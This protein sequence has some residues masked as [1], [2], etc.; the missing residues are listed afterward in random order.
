M[1]DLRE[2]FKALDALEAPDLQQEI[3]T[4]PLRPAP[5]P[6]RR[7]RL[8]AGTL[9]GL[10]AVLGIAVGGWA[11]LRPREAPRPVTEPTPGVTAPP[12][13]QE[14]FDIERFPGGSKAVGVRGRLIARAVEADRF[15]TLSA[16]RRKDNLCLHLNSGTVC[17]GPAGPRTEA[18]SIGVFRS[19]E[20]G[21]QGPEVTF[22]Y[23]PV[24]KR[25][26]EVS[27]SFSDGTTIRTSPI[28]GSPGFEV[29]FYVVGVR[30][31]ARVSTVLALD[32]GGNILGTVESSSD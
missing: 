26:A 30:G 28:S 1:S 22:V 6:D 14:V 19:S 24:V 12:Q 29:D 17:G 15:W 4:R 8:V 20:E 32:R 31:T 18:G 5:A 2:R 3:L 27:I 9:A 16:T 10:V 25:V 23:G 13:V 21:P 7:Q 11:L